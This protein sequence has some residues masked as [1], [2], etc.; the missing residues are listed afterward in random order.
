MSLHENQRSHIQKIREK[1]SIPYK[2]IVATFFSLIFS[3]TE[4]IKMIYLR[5]IKIFEISFIVN[6]LDFL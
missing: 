1:P 4:I 3:E 2:Y 6:R 5:L